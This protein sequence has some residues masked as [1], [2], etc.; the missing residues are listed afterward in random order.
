M[1]IMHQHLIS[2]YF[3]AC[4]VLATFIQHNMKLPSALIN[5]MVNANISEHKRPLKIDLR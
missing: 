4:L 5:L 3:P 1:S 2:C